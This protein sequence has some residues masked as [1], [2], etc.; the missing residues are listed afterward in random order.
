M[1]G[2]VVG[3]DPVPS[4]SSERNVLSRRAAMRFSETSAPWSLVGVTVC[5]LSS[6]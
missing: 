4:V 3:N 6:K 1:V 5:V 2:L